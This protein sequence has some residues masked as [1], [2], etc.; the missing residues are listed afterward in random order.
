MFVD[1]VLDDV[2]VLI[3]ML[4]FFEIG[5]WCFVCFLIFFDVGLGMFLG[6]GLFVFII[7]EEVEMFC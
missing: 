7:V 2:F 5:Y 4:L 3:L 1:D 6:V